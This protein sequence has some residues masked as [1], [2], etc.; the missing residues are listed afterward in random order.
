MAAAAIIG[1]SSTPA[2]RSALRYGR[3]SAFSIS[4][5]APAP[6]PVPA[7]TDMDVARPS[8]QGP[9]MIGTATALTTAWASW[10]SGHHEPR[11]T[12][13]P[14]PISVRVS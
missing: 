5:P 14:R 12:D 3:T 11:A 1:D 8:A 6:L 4:T 13:P 10:G 2:T 9:A 7:V